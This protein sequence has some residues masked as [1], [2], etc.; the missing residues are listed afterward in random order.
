MKTN[1][2]LVSLFLLLP[3]LLGAQTYTNYYTGNVNGISTNP[4]GGICMM[5]GATEHDEAMK[6]FLERANGGDIL[7][8]RTSGSD[9]YNDYMYA[10]L[11]VNVNSVETIVFNSPLA[12]NEDYIQQKIHGA[13]AI[14]FAGGDQWNYV[15]YWRGTMIET[16]INDGLQNRNI[17]IGGTSAGMAILG[18]YYFSAENGTVTSAQALANPYNINMSVDSTHF[19]ENQFLEDVI[20]DTHYDDPDRK[21]R[22]TSFL[23]RILA[24]YNVE[25][26]GI[27][28]NEY[29][30][31][32]I[33]GS[34]LA[35]VYGDYPNYEEA[36][37]FLQPNCELEDPSPENCSPS[38]ALEWNR[39]GNA[40]KVYKVYGTNNGMNTF[41]LSDWQTCD[42]GTWQNWY[43]TNG[44]LIQS[45]GLPI[46]CES[47][48]IEDVNNEID[49]QV[50]PNPFKDNLTINIAGEL[51]IS[52]YNVHGEMIYSKIKIE[53][54]NSINV[55]LLSSG[56]YFLEVNTHERSFYY[57]VYKE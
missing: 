9:G 55:S 36:A 27:A 56:M 38:N 34:G 48:G 14:W 33:N 16:L 46:D 23:A 44:S 2:L 17:V 4:E 42:G 41:D 10:D 5:G 53:N 15:S 24:D 18:K 40:V 11:G 26:K 43:V 12:V 20:T 37:Y 57:K 28:C 54:S 3:I 45:S 1:K 51:Q 8:L 6:W 7:V 13:E 49:I 22:H 50:Y 19:L 25:A 29:T 21:G 30:A 52:I 47:V 39:N 32:C 35:R 31:V